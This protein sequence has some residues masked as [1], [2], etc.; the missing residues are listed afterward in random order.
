MKGGLVTRNQSDQ[1]IPCEGQG[2]QMNMGRVIF[3]F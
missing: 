2:N 3:K 1:G